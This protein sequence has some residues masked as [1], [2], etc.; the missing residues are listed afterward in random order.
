MHLKDGSVW[1]R[2]CTIEEISRKKPQGKE[3]GKEL[4]N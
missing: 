4:K 1:M 3:I 2:A